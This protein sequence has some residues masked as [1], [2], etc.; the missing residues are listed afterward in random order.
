MEW[1]SLKIE[2]Y[3]IEGLPDPADVSQNHQTLVGKP[4]T[5]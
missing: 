5:V 3:T 1:G 4:T 2:R